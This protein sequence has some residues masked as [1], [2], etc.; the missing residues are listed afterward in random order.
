[1]S[2]IGESARLY[3][4][5][6]A[7]QALNLKTCALRFWETEFPQLQPIRTTSGQRL[8]SEEHVELLR[9][10][11]RLLYDRGLTI[12][13]A[14][15]VL[16]EESDGPSSFVNPEASPEP[17]FLHQADGRIL[18]EALDELKSLRRLLQPVEEPAEQHAVL[19]HFI[20]SSEPE[21]GA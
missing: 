11:Q 15:R 13:G 19:D 8:Y 2:K 12:P 14:R 16:E 18:K 20:F 7:A 17:P 9:R 6:E 3:R 1:M 10:I 21:S 5:G 4:I